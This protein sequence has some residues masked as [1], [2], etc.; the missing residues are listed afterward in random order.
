[1]VRPM[2]HTIRPEAAELLAEIDRFLTETG[3]TRSRFGRDVAN[4]PGLV[5][6]IANG[7]N[8][9]LAMA[10]KIRAHMQARAA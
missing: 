6:G 7:R 3:T 10:A 2:E 1:M 5:A 4:D 8:I 9:T